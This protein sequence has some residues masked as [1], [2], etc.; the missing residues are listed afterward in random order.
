MGP[1]DGGEKGVEVDCALI[2]ERLLLS[3]DCTCGLPSSP[4][5]SSPQSGRGVANIDDSESDNVVVPSMI[6][7]DRIANTR[8]LVAAAKKPQQCDSALI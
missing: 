7:H 8:D 4:R 6:G 5:Q 1:G 3:R 2:V